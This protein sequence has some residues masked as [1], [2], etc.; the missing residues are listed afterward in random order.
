MEWEFKIPVDLDDL[1]KVIDADVL[2]FKEVIQNSI[3]YPRNWLPIPF[4]TKQLAKLIEIGVHNVGDWK[5]GG[6]SLLARSSPNA[7]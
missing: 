4:V 6:N 1:T 2:E 5:L 7:R 3:G